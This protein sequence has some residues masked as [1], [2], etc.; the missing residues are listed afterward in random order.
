VTT[1]LLSFSRGLATEPK[2][3][4]QVV[5]ALPAIEDVEKWTRNNVEH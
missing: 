5:G 1:F 3:S 2:E 4:Q